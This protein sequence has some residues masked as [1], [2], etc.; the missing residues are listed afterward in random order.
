MASDVDLEKIAD[1]TKNFSG[2]EIEGLVRAAQSCAFNRCT[3]GGSK[4]EVDEEAIRSVQVN[5][6]DFTY[7]F[8]NDIKPALGVKERFTL[9]LNF[10]QNEHLLFCLILK[11]Q[12]RL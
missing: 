5:M 2:A 12:G 7:A 6:N 4:V 3:S 11:Q 8:Q 9:I 10:A 1:M